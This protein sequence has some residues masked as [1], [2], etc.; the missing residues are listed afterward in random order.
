MKRIV[1]PLLIS[2]C[3]CACAFAAGDP[4]GT[5]NFKN[6]EVRQILL[7]YKEMSGLDV[8]IDSRVKAVRS[9]V[10]IQPPAPLDKAEATKLIEKA[11]LDQAGVV[12]TRLDDKRASATW[13]DHL[14]TVAAN[15]HGNEP[16]KVSEKDSPLPNWDDTIGLPAPLGRNFYETDNRYPGYL[17]CTYEIRENHYDPSNEPGWF[18][19]ALIQIRA[20]G[21]RR[22]PKSDWIVVVIRNLAE[23]KD[24]KT[25]EQSFKAGAV[26][27][28]QRVFN[29]EQD[30]SVDISRAII[31]RHPVVY[32]ARL[33]ANQRWRIAE[34]HQ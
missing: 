33:N 22:F 15:P 24:V 2:S 30:L 5:L 10:S 25:F 3:L 14:P 28:A 34:K 26:F 4:N 7:I 21:A 11:L 18:D 29:R 8:V 13:N 12:L 23:H 19:S 32:D 27:N 16:A 6:A 31:D 20:Y 17:L 9:P 1:L